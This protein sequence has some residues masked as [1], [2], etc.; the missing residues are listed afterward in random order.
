MEKAK[1]EEHKLTEDQINTILRGE[2]PEG[3][4]FDLYKAW[5]A[6]SN[7]IVRLKLKGQLV[8]EAA[9]MIFGKNS[10]FQAKGKSY[11]KPIEEEK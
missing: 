10:R 4:P 9:E 5:R 8:F 3:M 11:V 2:R 1:E 6:Y 7:K